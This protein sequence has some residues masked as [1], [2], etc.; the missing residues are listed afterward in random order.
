[1]VSFG[2]K[3]TLGPVTFLE[4]NFDQFKN[5]PTGEIGTK[6]HK[7][8]LLIQAAAKAQVGVAT[9]ALRDSIYFIH[10]RTGMFQEL[11][12]GSD[13]SIALIHHEGSR[14]HQIRSAPPKMLRFSS[15]GRMVYTHEVMHPGTKP[16]K[17]LSDNLK[18]SYV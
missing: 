13:N 1:M 8:G 4:P 2:F 6:L 18:L 9:G 14:P 3:T 16:N 7:N 12:I 5:A 15:R 10:E 11:R 17:Y